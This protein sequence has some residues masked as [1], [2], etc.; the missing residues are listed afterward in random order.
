MTSAA[1]L[2]L[3]ATER[4]HFGGLTVQYVINGFGLFVAGFTVRTNVV[5][6]FEMARLV[7][8]RLQRM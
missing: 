3:S 2:G 6:N 1:V 8:M 4:D 5:W 7:D